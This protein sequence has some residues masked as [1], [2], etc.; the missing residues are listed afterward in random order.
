[1]AALSPT[2]QPEAEGG[3]RHRTVCAVGGS[4]SAFR[5]ARQS[6]A[7][8]S[9]VN[10]LVAV[11]HWARTAAAG[12]IRS[13]D[14]GHGGAQHRGEQRRQVEVALSCGAYDAGE[15]LLGVGA[16][17]GAVA[18]AHLADDDG[19][20]DGLFGAPVGGVDR[21]VPQEREDGAEFDGQVRGE[22]LGV[23]VRRRVVDQPAD[24]GEQSAAGGGQTVVADT[25]GVAPVA[26]REGG[27]QGV[28]HL[29][30]P[31]AV[32]MLLEQLLTASSQVL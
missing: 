10:S 29:A 24:L 15:D 16:L 13:G 32:G 31:S 23:V 14:D 25:T 11:R 8:R 2:S 18:A 28:L 5:P 3:S 7:G 6:A 17:S 4:V 19:G 20:P 26:Q 27:L 21:R 1:M 30:G 9:P 22:A 12:R